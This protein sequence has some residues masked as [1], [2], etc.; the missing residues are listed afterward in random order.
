M[1]MIGACGRNSGKTELACRLIKKY[2]PDYKVITLKV[3]THTDKDEKY[4][5]GDEKHGQF[6]FPKE[7]YLLVEEEKG[8]SGKDTGKMLVA[9]SHKVYWLRVKEE[10]L[11]KGAEAFLALIHNG[12]DKVIVCES[13]SLRRAVTPG[14]FLINQN[15]RD[16]SIKPSCQDVLHLK[17]HIVRFDN[18]KFS[19]DI[20]AVDI[21]YVAGCWTIRENAAAIVLAGGKSS[22]MGQ[23]KSLLAA[24]DS[25]P[26]IE[27]IVS[28]LKDHF[29]EIMIGASDME[30]YRFLNLPVIPDLERGQG[31]L[32]GIY[33]T[34]LQSQHEINFI[35]ACD[36]PDLDI[37]YVKKMMLEAQN[38]EIVVPVRSDGRLEPLL[39]VYRKSVLDKVKKVLGTGGRKITLLFDLANVR[40]LPLAADGD[41][42]ENLNTM[43]DYQN[44]LKQQRTR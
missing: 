30:K 18:E 26:L 34:L 24:A 13:N 11:I 1:I 43:E 27:K 32:M 22:R 25:V 39:A 41:W 10:Y 2:A 3:T 40:Y 31:P 14:L 19:F 20:D 23:D 5:S 42:Y 16:K 37:H 36:I 21:N 7:G 29:Q 4:S 38:H 44:Y 17:D 15:V 33:S 35:V 8:T 9:G 28:Q 6:H 12:P